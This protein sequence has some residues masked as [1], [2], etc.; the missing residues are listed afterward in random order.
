MEV[1]AP[2][3]DAVEAGLRVEPAGEVEGGLDEEE[4]AVGV[5]D[6]DG[7]V[8]ELAGDVEEE[9]DDEPLVLEVVAVAEPAV[10]V[11]GERGGG[12][13]AGAGRRRRRGGEG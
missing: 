9:E 2:D 1:A 4:L 10:E 6:A 3:E 7:E 11:E 12:G 5:P 13:G 8:G